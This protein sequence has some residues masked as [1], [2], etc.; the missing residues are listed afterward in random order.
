M[1][2]PAAL[3][4]ELTTDP[5]G[6][7]YA[8]LVA[9]GND[10]GVANILNR[11]S[12]PGA[13]TVTVNWLAKS[14]LAAVIVQAVPNLLQKDAGTQAAWTFYFQTALALD[15][16]NPAN[17]VTAA[18]FANAVTAGLLTQGQVDAAIKRVGSRAEVLWGA[19][20]IVTAAD[21]GA[22]R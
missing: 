14:D 11:P 15:G 8:A 10:P 2:D 9:V 12:G 13:A 17:P 3:R 7:G 1:I 21:V 18:L 20:T 22:A 16:V 6:L 5:A 4:H 19:G